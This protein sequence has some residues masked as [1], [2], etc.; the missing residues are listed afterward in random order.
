MKGK[1]KVERSILWHR[2]SRVIKWIPMVLVTMLLI[3][4][5]LGQVPKIQTSIINEISD[6]ISKN[7]SFRLS[8][9]HA[10]LTWYDE[11]LL[12]DVRLYHKASDST[13]ISSREIKIDFSLIRYLLQREISGDKLTLNDPY[14]HVIK[15]K[16][17]THINI[18]LFI[19]ELKQLF[20]K[21][22]KK[23]TSISI[24][25]ILVVN[26]TFSFNNLEKKLRND[27][28]DF[29][30]FSYESIEGVLYNFSFHND[31]IGFKI[32]ELTALDRD[33][34]LP[35]HSFHS[36]FSFTPKRMNF[37]NLLL[38]IG[39]STISNSLKLEYQ[40]P[41]QLKYLIDSVSFNTALSETHLSK[42]DLSLFT[43]NKSHVEGDIEISGN[44]SGSLHR[45]HTNNISIGFGL[46][47]KIIGSG[48]F[49]GL[50][51]LTETF[52]DFN[53]D[54]TQIVASDLEQYMSE[55]IFSKLSKLGQVTLDGS[56]VGF[57]KDFVSNGYLKTDIG[58]I[59]CDINLK[60]G[61]NQ[62]A[63]YEGFLLLDHFKVNKVF[64][65][66]K[67]IENIT[68]EG[69]IKG[70]G[71]DIENSNMDV[72]ITIDSLFYR[73][74]VLTNIQTK[75]HFERQFLNETGATP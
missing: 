16:D 35:I 51:N 28:K 9:G 52:I 17:S 40:S 29:N 56:F 24:D 74:I 70:N 44:L 3:S 75:G 65:E 14:F 54:K 67:H 1:Q 34:E 41:S 57:T 46:G 15:E 63:R 60:V 73:D 4:F 43:R 31:S 58:D 45:L 47:S 37:T 26:G 72:N 19:Y 61:T 71:L 27:I 32:E 21:S 53:F 25:E 38:N 48:Y 12:K 22:P 36:T 68:M 66:L 42:N 39:E 20:K 10:N 62:K 23:K 30:H 5:A 18:N 6:L 64:E 59:S 55:E 11:M 8:I 33:Q 49:Y 2:L 69:N 50:P 13:M 7:T